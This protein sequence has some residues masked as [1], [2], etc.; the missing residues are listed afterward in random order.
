MFLVVAAGLI[1]SV[2]A[3]GC[4]AGPVL[5]RPGWPV[6][7]PAIAIACWIAAL[8]GTFAGLTGAVAV[9]LLRSPAP[10]HGLLEWLHD[11]VHAH[12]HSGVALAAGVG[13]VTLFACAVRLARGLP[14]LWRAMT[15]R[16][17]HR[18]MLGLIAREDGE[19][20]DVLVLEHPV[21]VA[22]CLPSRRGC[23]VIS[24]GARDRLTAAQLKAV[25]AHERAHLRQRHH[26]LLLL[27]DLAYVL[28]PWLPTVRR[29]GAS[30][31]LLL[32]MAADDVAARR[33]GRPALAGALRKL[34]IAPGA[35]G[36]LAATGSD[37]RTLTRRLARLD[38]PARRLSR[39]RRT[40]AWAFFTC[41]I[42]APFAVI[43]VVVGLLLPC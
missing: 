37:G 18:Q 22:Y 38:V 26:A 36:A 17:R 6:A 16:R 10:G 12:R 24:T 29:A 40:A 20:A 42:G 32:E 11:C 14:R 28:L 34:A 27:L 1:V 35:A 31:P 8:S 25:L 33:C 15:H 39:A 7:N 5:D 41:A 3:L 4:V 21:P 9:A 30:L 23:I 19:H 13:A 43:T 2:V